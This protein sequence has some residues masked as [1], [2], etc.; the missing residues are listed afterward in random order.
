MF[1]CSEIAGHKELSVVG[2]LDLTAEHVI[3]Y[4]RIYDIFRNIVQFGL[5]RID[6]DAPGLGMSED[7]FLDD[8][9]IH[10]CICI[11][12]NPNQQ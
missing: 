11:H 2:L 1:D 5:Q 8:L 9:L 6:G 10:H 4:D 12:G 7:C 3:L